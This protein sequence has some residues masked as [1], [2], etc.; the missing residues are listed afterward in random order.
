MSIYAAP[1]SLIGITELPSAEEPAGQVPQSVAEQSVAPVAV[2]PSQTCSFD[3][4]CDR[5]FSKE[6]LPAKWLNLYQKLLHVEWQW[7]ASSMHLQMI[8]T[9][10]PDLVD[11]LS[12]VERAMEQMGG[13]LEALAKRLQQQPEDLTGIAAE[14]HRIS[15][16]SD[17]I[18]TEVN[19]L[20]TT[21]AFHPS[22]K[23]LAPV[24]FVEPK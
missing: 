9:R 4:P 12:A 14:V 1:P 19:A 18:S 16:V 11:R 15:V 13:E 21:V 6:E 10:F 23:K 22:T 8:P 5:A 20:T 3:S 24:R 2:L 17:W 7:Q